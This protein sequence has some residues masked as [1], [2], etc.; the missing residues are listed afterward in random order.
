LHHAV[1]HS[2]HKWIS[3]LIT[4]YHILA[5]G[6]TVEELIGVAA[7]APATAEASAAATTPATLPGT[8]ATLPSS[9]TALP[10]TA[11]A[12]LTATTALPAAPLPAAGTIVLELS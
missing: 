9:A 1:E 12:T 11:A 3:D 10:G 6:E 4:G 2:L 5:T 7:K 8:A